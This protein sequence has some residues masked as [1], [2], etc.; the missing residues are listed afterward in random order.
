MA[1]Y[2]YLSAALLQVVADIQLLSPS[3]YYLI[4]S[5]MLLFRKIINKKRY[6]ILNLKSQKMCNNNQNQ[7]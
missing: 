5:S 7:N 6:D 2:N 4:A 1:G 3:L